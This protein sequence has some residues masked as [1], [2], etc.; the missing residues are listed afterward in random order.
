MTLVTYG[1]AVDYIGGE[2]KNYFQCV[3]CLTEQLE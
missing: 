1:Y 2:F 3:V